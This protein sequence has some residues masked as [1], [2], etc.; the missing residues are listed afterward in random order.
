VPK[1]LTLNS[2]DMNNLEAE[3]ELTYWFTVVIYV[4]KFFYFS[5]MNEYDTTTLLRGGRYNESQYR[6]FTLALRELL[7]LNNYIDEE[8]EDE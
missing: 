7:I 2:R 3:N 4:E 1:V 6:I 8:R 5:G